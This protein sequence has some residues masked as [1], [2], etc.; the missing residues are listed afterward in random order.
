MTT[1]DTLH[2]PAV[3]SASARPTVVL[4]GTGKTGRRLV[5]HLRAEG[6]AVRPVGRSTSLPFDWADR[7]TWDAAISGSRA[8]YIAYSPDLAVP[9]S[10]DDIAELLTRLEGAGIEHATLLSGRGEPEAQDAEEALQ[11]SSLSWSVVRASWF[12]QN[13]SESYLRDPILEGTLYLPAVSAAEP[14][15]DADDIAAVAAAT[16]LDNRHAGEVYEVTGPELLT[17][18]QIAEQLS[19]ALGRRISYVPI[20]REEYATAARAEGVPEPVVWLLDYLFRVVLDGRN[21]SLAD[22]VQRALGREPRRFAD[23]ARAHA[24]AGTWTPGGDLT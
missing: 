2:T 5:E 15:I 20:S 13:F 10:G 3:S 7:S 14:F 8:A 18:D 12:F 4:G 24:A 19:S 17:F 21:E 23:F 1:T 11:R 9:G 6:V 16:L 22:G